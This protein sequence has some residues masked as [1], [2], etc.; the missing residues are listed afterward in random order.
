M[1]DLT[2]LLILSQQTGPQWNPEERPVPNPIPV[3]IC[4]EAHITEKGRKVDD[5]YE[6]TIHAPPHKA[7]ELK[8]LE[9]GRKRGLFTLHQ[10]QSTDS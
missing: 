4:V 5:K 7:G 8:N 10:C 6:I 3:D 1:I 2:F 9:E